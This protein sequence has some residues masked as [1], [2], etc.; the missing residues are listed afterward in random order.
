[1]NIENTLLKQENIGSISRGIRSIEEMISKLDEA[2]GLDMK[3]KVERLRIMDEALL[4]DVN[5]VN[6]DAGADRETTEQLY[7]QIKK[8]TDALKL[9][10]EALSLRRN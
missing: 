9:E 7:Q 3:P 6:K 2:D 10:M 5:E 4:R 8:E 1:M